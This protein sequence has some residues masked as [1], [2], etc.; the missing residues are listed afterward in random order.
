MTAGT[1]ADTSTDPGASDAQV[2]RYTQTNLNLAVNNTTSQEIIPSRQLRSSRRTSRHVAGTITGE[3][4]PG[5]YFD[6]FEAVCRG[7]RT[8]AGETGSLVAIPSTGHVR[9][10]LAIERYNSDLDLSRL[11]TECRLTGFRLNV[12]AEGNSTIEW[13]VMGRGRKSLST[14]SAPYFSSPTDANALDVCN[15]L[16][17]SMKLDGS[18]VGLVTAATINFTMNSEAPNVLGQQFCPDIL[19]GVANVSGSFTFL[20]DEADTGSTIFEN[21]TEVAVQLV[22][23]NAATGGDSVT[24]DLPRV[25][26]QT[27]DEEVRGDLSQPVT[28]AFQALEATSGD[29]LSTIQITDSTVTTAPPGP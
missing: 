27:G 16:S 7:T 15:S 28:C 26:L 19:L 17:G 14:S 23:T 12:P 10:K 25:K 20:L 4:S 21:E 24:F 3:L 11:Y 18:Q 5:T 29:I 9:R 13:S 1:E 22:L 2:L 6:F 8:S